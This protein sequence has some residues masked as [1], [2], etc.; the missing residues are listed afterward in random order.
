MSIKKE[1]REICRKKSKEEN[2]KRAKARREE[3]YTLLKRYRDNKDTYHTISVKFT[4]L[5]DFL[6][7]RLVRKRL[8]IVGYER[9]AE[10][11]GECRYEMVYVKYN[12]EKIV[13]FSEEGMIDSYGFGLLSFIWDILHI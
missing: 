12:N 5:L 6:R 11:E 9:G 3:V 1:Y 7:N 13:K 4:L 10:G 8:G 2:C